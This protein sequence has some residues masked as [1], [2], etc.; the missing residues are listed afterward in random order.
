MTAPTIRT[1]P[2][3]RRALAQQRK[4]LRHWAKD[5]GAAVASHLTIYSALSRMIEDDPSNGGLHAAATR[6]LIGVAL[7]HHRTPDCRA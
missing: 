1:K 4:Q 7:A 2:A 3:F 6:A 5:R